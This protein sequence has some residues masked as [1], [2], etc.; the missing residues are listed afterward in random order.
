MSINTNYGHAPGKGTPENDEGTADGQVNN[1]QNTTNNTADFRSKL[2]AVYARLTG[3]TG[4]I[5]IDR[6]ISA[7]SILMAVLAAV[8]L[9][10]RSV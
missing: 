5:Y 2:I 8:Y 4:R 9:M 10:W 3:A 1:P 6:G 7:D